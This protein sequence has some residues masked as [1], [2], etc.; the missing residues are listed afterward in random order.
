MGSPEPSI[1]LEH[2]DKR[3]EIYSIALP[4]GHELMLLHSLPG[5]MRGG[6][7]HDCDEIVTVLSGKMRYH[8]ITKAMWDSKLWEREGQRDLIDG[9]S[10]FN[11]AGQI[12]M[13]EFLEDT[14]VIE[15]KKAKKGEWRQE[16]YAPYREKVEASTL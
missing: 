8:K 12:H 3:G 5:A 6:H 9:D 13:G 4:D 14:W 7:S 11:E 16:N 15:Y 1:K 10:S 2:A